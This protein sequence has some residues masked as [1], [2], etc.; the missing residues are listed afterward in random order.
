MKKLVTNVC[1]IGLGVLASVM[2]FLPMFQYFS[3]T[4][5]TKTVFEKSAFGLFGNLADEYVA[6]FEGLDATYS[7]VFKIIAAV[8]VGIAIA[9]VVVF[10]V[11][12]LIELLN[13]KADYSNIKKLVGMVLV[14]MAVL[15]V[16][17]TC[18]Y[19]I[20]NNISGELAKIF[21]QRGFEVSNWFAYLSV[22]LGFAGAG[23][24]AMMQE[25]KK[26]KKRK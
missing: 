17:A 7:N 4:G 3:V 16:I 10:A 6:L 9:C 15:F 21:F 8:V 1:S 13:K 2:A 23:I 19:F 14:A 22:A 18:I 25:T 24:C 11:L 20:A 26:G 12:S 5:E